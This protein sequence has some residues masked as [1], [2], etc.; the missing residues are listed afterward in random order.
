MTVNMRSFLILLLVL[1]LPI[2]GM[3]QLLMPATS[4]VHHPMADMEGMSGINGMDDADQ[5]CREGQDQGPT[6]VC[7]SGQECKTSSL[8]Q[9][10]AAKA[11]VIPA[12]NPVTTL[13][14]DQI[15]SRLLDAVW[16]PPRV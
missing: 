4:S 9:I 6:T 2:N 14:N 3:A 13:Y 10:A 12:A 16:R 7:K 11:D 5:D 15:P 8:V 1:T